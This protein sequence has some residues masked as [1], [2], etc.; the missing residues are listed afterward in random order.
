MNGTT[1]HKT[2]T[3][4]AFKS[5]IEEVNSLESMNINMGYLISL[6]R[7]IDEYTITEL[8]RGEFAR[9]VES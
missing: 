1:V 9:E 3:E 5:D 2:D 8:R 4:R 6:I 7:L